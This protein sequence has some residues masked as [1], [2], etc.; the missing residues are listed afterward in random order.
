M[1]IWKNAP[2]FTFGP[3]P[4]LTKSS[5]AYKG[6]VPPPVG[7]YALYVHKNNIE[8]LQHLPKQISPT[9]SSENGRIL[10]EIIGTL[11]LDSGEFYF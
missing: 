4:T 7:T 2:S 5:S 6:A 10:H 8:L 3:A 1:K 9:E 11:S